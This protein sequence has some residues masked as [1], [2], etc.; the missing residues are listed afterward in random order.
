MGDN[1]LRVACVCSELLE[2]RFDGGICYAWIT[3]GSAMDI[4]VDGLLVGC[5]VVGLSAGKWGRESTLS[6]IWSRLWRELA[7]VDDTQPR[8][9]AHARRHIDAFVGGASS[10]VLTWT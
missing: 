8:A 3:P 5:L 1:G 7:V 9:G 2:C 10:L 4:A 6:S